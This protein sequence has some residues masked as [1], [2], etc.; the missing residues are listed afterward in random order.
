MI[1]ILMKKLLF[2]SS[3]LALGFMSGCSQADQNK[4]TKT[5]AAVASQIGVIDSNATSVKYE[6]E[7]KKE[8]ILT[9][10]D[11]F[12]SA[13]LLDAEGN[14]YALKE[15]PAGSGM[16]LK[17]ENGVSVHTKGDEGIIELSKE[18]SFN[19]KEVK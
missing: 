8:F 9:T 19:V 1:G 7:D 12:A 4:T 11:N 3:L 13:T 18:R 2:I 5:D 17:G 14:S 10:K 15:S 16:L 6:T